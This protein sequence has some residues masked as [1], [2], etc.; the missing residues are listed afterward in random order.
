MHAINSLGILDY[1]NSEYRYTFNEEFSLRKASLKTNSILKAI[2][3]N[4]I[5]VFISSEFR[6]I[7]RENNLLEFSFSVLNRSYY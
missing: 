1:G 2:K 4:E 5:A 7:A 3:D 6:K